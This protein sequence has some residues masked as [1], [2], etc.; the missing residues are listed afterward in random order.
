MKWLG[1]KKRISMRETIE[2]AR[3]AEQGC[4]SSARLFSEKLDALENEKNLRHTP[5]DLL[6]VRRM[7]S[8][9]SDKDANDIDY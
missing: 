3:Q 2:K 1:Q 8:Y 6:S 9:D 5:N 7:F 4:V